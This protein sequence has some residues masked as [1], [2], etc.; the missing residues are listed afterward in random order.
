MLRG[1]RRRPLLGSPK[2]SR[3]P[4]LPSNSSKLPPVAEGLRT[5]PTG[6]GSHPPRIS[7]VG[8]CG[9]SGAAHRWP[10]TFVRP[11][12]ARHRQQ[13]RQRQEQHQQA[14]FP[15]PHRGSAQRGLPT[16]SAPGHS[17][18]SGPRLAS[19]TG[20][21]ARNPPRKSSP[22]L[23]WGRGTHRPANPKRTGGTG[24]VR[25]AARRCTAAPPSSPA[26]LPVLL[27]APRG[28]RV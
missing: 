11:P 24:R 17:R 2:R 5:E 15:G 13:L 22:A 26:L 21:K 1:L 20:G 27:R 12:G 3:P 25:L 14:G 28:S 16:P 7:P 6:P 9:P 4:L 23:G 19:E 10:L 18:T 8:P